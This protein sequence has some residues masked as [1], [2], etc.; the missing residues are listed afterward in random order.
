MRN[1][2]RTPP[3]EILARVGNVAATMNF[4]GSE[5]RPEHTLAGRL[6]PLAE[7]LYQ[8]VQKAADRPVSEPKYSANFPIWAHNICSELTKSVFRKLVEAAPEKDK[9]NAR[10]YGRIVGM[11]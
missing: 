5:S 9:F 6:I 10:N 3:T 11:L 7:A 2:W 8:A 4:Y 1:G